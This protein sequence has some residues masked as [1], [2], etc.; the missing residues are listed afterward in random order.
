MAFDSL[1]RE[2]APTPFSNLM[3]SSRCTQKVFAFWL[4]RN[5]NDNKNGGELT[6][7]G[8]DPN[9]YTGDIIY[10]PV[11]RKQY[12]EFQ[13]D[14][15]QVDQTIVSSNFRAIAD[16]GTTLIIGPPSDVKRIFDLIKLPYGSSG[17]TLVSC[18]AIN[19]LPPISFVIASRQ[20]TLTPQDYVVK[21]SGRCFVGFSGSDMGMWILGDGMHFFS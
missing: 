11:T 9:H 8:T 6:V 4:N 7:C 12:W 1:A 3:K 19:T 16:T 21:Q 5:E 10:T 2:G 15:V 18:N 17:G 20:F 13:A 14:R